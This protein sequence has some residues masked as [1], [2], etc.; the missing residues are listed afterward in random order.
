VR[1]P[2]EVFVEDLGS[3]NGI[4]VN[5]RRVAGSLQILDGDTIS[6]GR[7]ALAVRIGDDDELEATTLVERWKNAFAEREPTPRGAGADPRDRRRHER[8]DIELQIVYVSSELE[9][10]VVSRDLSESGV[11][12]R[13]QVLEPI[14]TTCTL[15]MQGVASA[16]VKLS[17]VV[18]RVVERD[19]T[20]TGLGVEFVGLAGGERALIRAICE[21]E[22][23]RAMHGD[24]GRA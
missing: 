19:D 2:D 1:R 4:Q 21:R 12:V 13:S 23:R 18:R 3:A 9:I 16:P 17:G 15:M 5:G 8:R 11:F 24:R 20:A 7:L 14:G 10:E 6:F 22:T